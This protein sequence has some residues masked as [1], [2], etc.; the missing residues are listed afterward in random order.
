ME[1]R[2]T[3]LFGLAALAA[4]RASAPLFGQQRQPVPAPASPIDTIVVDV[5]R[6]NVL[7]TVTDK[8]GRFITDLS[9]E[10]FEV[11]E[12]KREQEILEFNRETDLPLRL[13]VLIDTSNSIR[14]SFRFLQDAALQFVQSVVRAGQDRATVMSFDTVPQFV[15]DLT[16][17]M[18]T[19]EKGIRSL[20][21]GGGTALYDAIALACQ[22]KLIQDQPRH[23]YRR[24]LILLSDGDDTQSHFSRDQALE[25]AHKADAAIFAISTNVTRAPSDGDKVLKYLAAET[26]GTTFFP[27]KLEDLTQSFENIA[28]EM[29][30]QYSVL[31]SPNPLRADGQYHEVEVR[32]RTK[33]DF[34]VRARKGYY[35]PKF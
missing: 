33:K 5:T 24:A 7:Y 20:R 9:K 32:M 26:G 35:A 31:Y 30:H 17:Y 6:V 12:G 11:R 23:K 18:P 3:A 14:A 25:L 1:S 2:R 22:E 13:A 29:R 16:D 28:N 19:L 15:T 27:F 8:K 4:Q 21:P 10:D 34:I